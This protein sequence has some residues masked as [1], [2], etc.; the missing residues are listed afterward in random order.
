[1]LFSPCGCLLRFHVVAAGAGSCSLLLVDWCWFCAVA[2]I[3][4]LMSWLLFFVFCAGAV[5]VL[6][7]L[8]SSCG[9]RLL[10]RVAVLMLRLR[11][12]AGRCLLRWCTESLVICPASHP[13]QLATQPLQR[14]AVTWA[15][16]ASCRP[17]LMPPRPHAMR[18]NDRRIP[19]RYISP[20]NPLAPQPA[21][22]TSAR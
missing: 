21:Q 6:R 22:S 3:C 1:M 10:W 18:R 15:A 11:A 13:A 7:P 2:A 12:L 4:V 16:P 20:R 19:R 14:S 9:R 8:P 17:C 5:S